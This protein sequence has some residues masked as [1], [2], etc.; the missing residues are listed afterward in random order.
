MT[1][2]AEAPDLDVLWSF[3]GRSWH[4]HTIAALR[5]RFSA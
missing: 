2:A 4:S 5:I 1:L 3:K